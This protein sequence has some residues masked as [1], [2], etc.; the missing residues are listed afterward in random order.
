MFSDAGK[1]SQIQHL[2]YDLNTI[3]EYLKLKQ[4]KQEESIEFDKNLRNWSK[5]NKKREKIL[6]K[7]EKQSKATKPWA[8]SH[9][10]EPRLRWSVASVAYVKIPDGSWERN[11]RIR[12]HSKTSIST[13]FLH[14]CLFLLS[15]RHHYNRSSTFSENEKEQQ[16]YQEMK[17]KKKNQLI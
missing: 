15:S 7:E 5:T 4:L 11:C 13:Y 3:P 1:N 17:L 10:N 12:I 8:W 6:R 14:S 9:G 16:R 2:Q